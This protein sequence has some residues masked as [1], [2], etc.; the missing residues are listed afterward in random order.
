M[1]MVILLLTGVLLLIV[2][3]LAHLSY[4]SVW[5]TDRPSDRPTESVCQTADRQTGHS[6][7]TDRP[8]RP[9]GLGG[10]GRSRLA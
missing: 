9:V 3:F 4:S 8:D 2:K 5:L 6:R 1:E 7:Q 10:L